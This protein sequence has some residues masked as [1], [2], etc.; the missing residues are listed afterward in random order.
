MLDDLGNRV[1]LRMRLGNMQEIQQ[2]VMG[3]GRHAKVIAP[4]S[5]RDWVKK[6]VAA[7]ARNYR[8]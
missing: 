2:L 8:K 4:D 6:E 7:M 5:L 1:E 3:W